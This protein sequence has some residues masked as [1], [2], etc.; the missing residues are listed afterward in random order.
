MGFFR[1]TRPQR[2]DAATEAGEDAAA[3]AEGYY[4]SSEHK[5]RSESGKR[6]R[7]RRTPR[8]RAVRAQSLGMVARTEYLSPE[9]EALALRPGP[10]GLLDVRLE[11][12]RDRLL[13]VSPSGWINPKSRTAYK[14]GLHSFQITGT[15]FHEAAVKA[16]RF[17]PGSAV[18]LV[19]EPDNR[20]DPNA[21][22][23]YA[24]GG[25][26]KAGYVPATVAKRLS[27]LLDQ[28][29]ALVA[30]SVRGAGAGSEGTVPQIL[31]CER[32]LYEHLTRS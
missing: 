29:V 17:T 5:R 31:V 22:A 18:R 16:G 10:N 9:D 12:V 6:A 28:G 30:V 4:V 25:R 19:R 32:S 20:H 7:Q 27:K 23:I 3:R 8:D 2:P 15:A 26:S 14:A 13:V 11:R 21:I 1:R 24:E